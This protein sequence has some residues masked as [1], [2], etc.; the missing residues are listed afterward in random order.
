MEPVVV[1]AQIEALL[2]DRRAAF[3]AERAKELREQLDQ[4]RL[5]ELR[6]QIIEEER[7]RLLAEHAKNLGLRHLPKGV[8]SSE[9]DQ[10]LFS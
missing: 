5:A 4:E 1:V 10:K 3:E 9:D 6:N 7:K 2:E 8:L